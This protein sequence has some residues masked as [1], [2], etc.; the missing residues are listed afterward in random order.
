MLRRCMVL[1]SMSSDWHSVIQVKTSTVDNFL[2]SSGCEL[3][4]ARLLA[5]LQCKLTGVVCD[6]A[7]RFKQQN[8]TV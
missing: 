5:A 6:P 2:N 3:W 7:I 1:Q 8:G 4:L